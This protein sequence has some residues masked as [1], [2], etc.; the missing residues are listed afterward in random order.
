MATASYLPIEI[1]IAVNPIPLH[2]IQGTV[3]MR[4]RYEK[5]YGVSR[6]I[7]RVARVEGDAAPRAAPGRMMRC[8]T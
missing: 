7:I 8:A 1:N 2:P 5:A 3:I 4:K 6:I